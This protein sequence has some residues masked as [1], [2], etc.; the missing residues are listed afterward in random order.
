MM[1][2]MMPPMMPMTTPKQAT[3]PGTCSLVE[4]LDKRVLIILQDGR[5]LVGWL[6]SF[7]QFTNFVLEE[8][9]ERRYSGQCYGDVPLGLYIVRGENVVVL[10][11]IDVAREAEGA[12]GLRRV[13]TEEILQMQ[14]DEDESDE[15]DA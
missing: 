12:S 8:C 10:G 14:A 5:H 6:R 9:C 7:D 15:E 1:P 11:E 4:Q 3:L 2:M 13:S